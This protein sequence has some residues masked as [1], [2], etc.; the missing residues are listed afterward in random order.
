MVIFALH[1]QG[2]TLVSHH[3]EEEQGQ[4]MEREKGRVIQCVSNMGFRVTSAL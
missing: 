3:R 4:E 2:L 1:K